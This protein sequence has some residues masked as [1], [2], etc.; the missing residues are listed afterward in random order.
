MLRVLRIW[1]AGL[2]RMEEG[3]LKD[4]GVRVLPVLHNP[5]D[6]LSA[7]AF[8]FNSP[9]TARAFFGQSRGSFRSSPGVRVSRS[10]AEVPV[11]SNSVA[12]IAT[13]N[14]STLACVRLSTPP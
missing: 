5:A 6:F 3:P 7:G 8:R 13:R 12:D 10:C 1:I 2:L 11:N 14:G 9:V 4:L